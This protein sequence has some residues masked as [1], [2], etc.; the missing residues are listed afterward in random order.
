[1]RTTS[2]AARGEPARQAY[3]AKFT[4]S[5]YSAAKAARPELVAT[6]RGCEKRQTAA[7]MVP[8]LSANE[9]QPRRS[10]S[11]RLASS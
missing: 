2:A 5:A 8:Y 7:A 9:N 1:M 11:R 6:S 3:S 10:F 4:R